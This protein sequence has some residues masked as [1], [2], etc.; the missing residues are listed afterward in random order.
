MSGKRETLPC[1]GGDQLTFPVV[2]L[3]AFT[4]QPDRMSQRKRRETKQHPSRTRAGYQI[5]C[6]LVSL[7]LMC[8][9]LSSHPTYPVEVLHSYVVSATNK[10]DQRPQFLE[11][12][13]KRQADSRRE[14]EWSITVNNSI[15][16]EKK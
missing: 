13:A 2:L 4:G 7:H 10:I 12:H 11:E 5:S 16:R 6:W 8:D 1:I 9:I 14:H 15:E 3:L